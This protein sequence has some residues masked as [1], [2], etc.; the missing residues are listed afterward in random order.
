MRLLVHPVYATPDR[1]RAERSRFFYRPERGLYV[2]C[3]LGIINGL[4]RPT[5]RLLSIQSET[6]ENPRSWKLRLT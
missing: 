6:P 3:A 1:I 4:L 2:L 5:R